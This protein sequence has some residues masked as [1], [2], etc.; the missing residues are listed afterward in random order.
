MSESIIS[1]SLKKIYVGIDVHK[2]TYA[3]TVLGSDIVKKPAT[4]SA[5]PKALISFL[6]NNYQ[7]SEIFSVYE[8][9]FSGFYLHRKLLD[10]GI[11]NIV[12]N[13]S[14]IEI[15]ANKKIKTDKKDSYKLAEHL[16][17]G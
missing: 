10:S 9:G 15:S 8:M 2:K 16:S 5:C 1:P 17:L 12:V 3:V 13:P 7:N 6:K 4:M 14:S 11:K